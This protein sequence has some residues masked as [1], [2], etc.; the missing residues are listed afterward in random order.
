MRDLLDVLFPAS[1][2]GCDAAGR[3]ACARCLGA[4]DAQPRFTRPTPAPAGL[5]PVVTIAPYGGAVRGLLVAYKERGVATLRVPLAMALARAVAFLLARHRVASARIVPIPS[6]RAARRSRGADVVAALA[7]TAARTLRA[8]RRD[9]VVVRALAH[10]RRV[11]DSARLGADARR[12]NVHGSMQV[13]WPIHW[14]EAIPVI[15]VDDVV[16]SGATLAEAS[17]ALAASGA[18]VLGAATIAATQRRE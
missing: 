15:V 2:A 13:R 11:R 6:S 16:T 5:P 7:R 17:R 18:T 14:S 3:P 9:V 4:L 10:D 12:I 1:C 8:D